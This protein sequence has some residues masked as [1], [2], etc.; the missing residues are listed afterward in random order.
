MKNIFKQKKGITLIALV[1]TIIVL[2]ILAGISISML[3]GDNAI[4]QRTTDAKT[5][6]EKQNIIELAKTDILGQIADNKGENISTQQ[7]KTVLKT[8]FNENEVEALDIPNDV[9]STSNYELTTKKGEYKIKLSEIYSGKIISDNKKLD[10]YIGD[11]VTISDQQFYVIEDSP[12]SET[13][14]KLI[15]AQN[16]E[17]NSSSPNYNKQS[18]T[19]SKVAFS[20]DTVI[21]SQSAVK[22]YIDRYI[23]SLGKTIEEGRLIWGTEIRAL[24]GNLENFTTNECPSF[25]N[26]TSYW[27]DYVSGR[28]VY[29]VNG[30]QK[31]MIKIGCDSNTL[32]GVRPVLTILK[33]NI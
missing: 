5:N 15:T 17:T 7:L 25:I 20:E 33:S 2:L 23:T 11:I 9:S 24:G 6:T 21:Y 14:L 29:C 12:A 1:I 18:A 4:L 26:E 3:T 8:Y 13:L 22:L 32:G 28:G 30:E 10:Y 27:T 19:A 16:I 31:K